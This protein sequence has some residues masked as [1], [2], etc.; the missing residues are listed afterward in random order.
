RLQKQPGS[1]YTLTLR[2]GTRWTFA[3]PKGWGDPERIPLIRIEDRGNNVLSLD[4]D[5]RFRLKRVSDV[6][7]REISFEYGGC[8]LLETVR[9]FTGRSI[10]YEHSSEVEHLLRVVLP[11]VDGFPDGITA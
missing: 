1:E 6:S 8:G 3:R 2:A 11:P 4:Y 10:R 9:D 7:G 5:T